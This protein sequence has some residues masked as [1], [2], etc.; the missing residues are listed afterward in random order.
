MFVHSYYLFDRDDT[1]FIALTEMK[2]KQ[3]MTK[4]IKA[5]FYVLYHS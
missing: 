3:I 5:S 2:L 1:Y 4:S